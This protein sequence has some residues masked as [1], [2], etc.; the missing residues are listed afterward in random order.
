M[1]IE[2]NNKNILNDDADGGAGF[3]KN[4]GETGGGEVGWVNG[5][6]QCLCE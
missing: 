3:P 5:K 1:T 4:G 6:M 2:F